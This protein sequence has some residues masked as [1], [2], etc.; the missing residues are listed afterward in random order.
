MGYDTFK[1]EGGSAKEKL[2]GGG[3]VAE[4]A[5]GPLLGTIWWM[6]TIIIFAYVAARQVSNVYN[7]F[8]GWRS[9]VA[10][11]GYLIMQVGLWNAEFKWDEEGSSAYLAAAKKDKSLTPE[12][13][14]VMNMGD[15]SSATCSP[16]TVPS[17]WRLPTTVTRP[18]LSA[19]LSVTLLA[20]QWQMPS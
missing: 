17:I 12:E 3:K 6:W 19:C 8:L 5:P 11:A 16:L 2:I 20:C 14:E 4:K 1:T 18:W 15:V 7:V 10:L 13:L 9:A